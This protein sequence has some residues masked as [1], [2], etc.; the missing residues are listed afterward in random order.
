MGSTNI[1]A[2][3]AKTRRLSC[4]D[5]LLILCLAIAD[6]PSKLLNRRE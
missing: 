5:G 3:A 4:S 1:P 2:N 6:A